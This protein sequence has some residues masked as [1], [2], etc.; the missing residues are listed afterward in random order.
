MEPTDRIPILIHV[1]TR[2]GEPSG[3]HEGI[4]VNPL[5]IGVATIGA[6]SNYLDGD[7]LIKTLQKLHG[8][9]QEHPY[10]PSRPAEMVLPRE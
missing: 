4:M 8:N 9:A 10:L 5:S 1:R 7:Y 3:T 2:F 6:A